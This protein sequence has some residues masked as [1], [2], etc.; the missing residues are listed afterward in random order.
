MTCVGISTTQTEIK[1]KFQ[2]KFNQYEKK[3]NSEKR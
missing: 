3:L 1:N 2:Y